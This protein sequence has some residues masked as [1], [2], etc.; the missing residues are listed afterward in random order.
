MEIIN[1]GGLP[2]QITKESFLQ[3]KAS[4]QWRNHQI[5]QLMIELGVAQRRGQGIQTIIA[6][7]EKV[8]GK[9]PEFLLEPGRVAVTLPAAH[10]NV[11]LM[12]PAGNGQ[13]NGRNPGIAI[14]A[15]GTPRIDQQV[16]ESLAELGLAEAPIVLSFAEESFIEPGSKEWTDQIE[17]LKRK[18]REAAASPRLRELHLF[19]QGPVTI[20]MM[21]GALLGPTRKTYLYNYNP[22]TGSYRFDLLLDVHFLRA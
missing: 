21:L 5:A 11:L 16:I 13:L 10:S 12:Q 22:D 20:A 1:P 18:I 6:S 3:G 17:T 7:T 15:F 19:Y 4:P 14:V 8:S 2:D 9:K